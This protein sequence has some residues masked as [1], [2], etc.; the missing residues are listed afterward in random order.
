MS[1]TGKINFS[2]NILML[3]QSDYPPDIRITKEAKTLLN[4][5]YNVTLL[6]NNNKQLPVEENVEGTQVIRLSGLSFIP[7]KISKLV[8]LPLFFSPLW[9]GK[10]AALIKKRKIDYLHVHDLPLAPLAIILGR[11][12]KIPVIYDMHENYPAAMEEWK[13]KGGSFQSIIK[14]PKIAG[15]LNNYS[16]KRANKVIVVVKEQRDNLIRKG[17]SPEKIH[18]VGNTVDKDK[19]LDIAID[20]Y[21]LGKYEKNFIILYIGSFST[22][23]GLET[24][25]EAMKIL[26][27]HLPKSKLL[28]VGD[29]KNKNNLK[30]FVSSCSVDDFVEFV[31]WVDFSKVPS[32][33]HASHICIIPQPS[34]P[35]NDTTLPHKLFQY[36]LLAKPVLTSDAE[37]LKRIVTETKCGEVFRSHDPQDFAHAVRVIYSSQIQYGK[38]G[39]EAVLKKYNWQQTSKEL[40]NT[41]SLL[42]NNR[43]DAL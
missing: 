7:F 1:K 9:F 5:G 21:I 29:G 3:L 40:L 41:Y 13:S 36:M 39:R 43:K 4:H 33:L 27:V 20:D 37:P 8:R 30:A 34:N 28:L 17:L 26:R 31:G 16:L 22:E 19:L 32:Y 6:C 23:R 14:N 15:I 18:I 35:A 12:F 38:N 24:A 11:R 42:Q 25:I 2:K 10:A